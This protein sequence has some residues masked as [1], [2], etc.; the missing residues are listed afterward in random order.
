MIKKKYPQK[1]AA[2]GSILSPLLWRHF[3]AVFTKIFLD[4]VEDLKANYFPEIVDFFHL[5]Y[6]DDKL[7]VMV[8]EVSDADSLSNDDSVRIDKIV[9]NVRKLLETATTMVGTSLN[10][11]KSEV[12]LFE[13][14]HE[15]IEHSKDNFIQ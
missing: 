2:Q 10:L 13:A 4:A 5:S 12:V 11:E 8:V 9:K 3:D 14:L 15:H 6:A 7:F 1:S